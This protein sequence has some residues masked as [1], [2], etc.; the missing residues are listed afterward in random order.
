MNILCR[1]Y[2]F[3]GMWSYFFP[4]DSIYSPI[5]WAKSSIRMR[6]IIIGPCSRKVD[7][8]CMNTCAQTTISSTIFNINLIYVIEVESLLW[9]QILILPFSSSL[10]N[11]CL[12]LGY[13]FFEKLYLMTFFTCHLYL[14]YPNLYDDLACRLI[15]NL[16]LSLLKDSLELLDVEVRGTLNKSSIGWT[17]IYL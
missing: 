13:L 1:Y 6:N 9:I 5:S 14:E 8:S 12:K 2:R 4:L 7:V 3:W 17:I 11:L 16:N 10:F 15:E